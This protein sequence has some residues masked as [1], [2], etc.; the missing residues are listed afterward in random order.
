M[1]WTVSQ[2]TG[3]TQDTLSVQEMP[4]HTHSLP[5]PDGATGT[6]GDGQPRNNIKPSLA[7][8]YMIVQVR[9]FPIQ[10]GTTIFEPYLGQIMLFC[11]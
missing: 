3:T 5:P 1:S 7:L 6:N 4:A 11:R 10:G 9:Y 8:T 2:R